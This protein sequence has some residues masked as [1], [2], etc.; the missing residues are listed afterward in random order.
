MTFA[1]AHCEDSMA[2]PAADGIVARC[3]RYVT[4]EI[5]VGIVASPARIK[6]ACGLAREINSLLTEEN[7]KISCQYQLLDGIIVMPKGTV[8]LVLLGR[9]VFSRAFAHFAIRLARAHAR[10][11]IDFLSSVW[12][13]TIADPL[14]V[15][16]TR[17][18]VGVVCQSFVI[19]SNHLLR[20]IELGEF[21]RFSLHIRKRN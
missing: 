9:K 19:T 21:E 12:A 15:K 5:A 13:L 2:M 14:G 11:E 16:P 20:K 4:C 6:H 7:Q 17:P 18:L 3:P 1:H 8:S 10:H